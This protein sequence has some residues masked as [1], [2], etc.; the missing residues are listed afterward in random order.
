MN[1]DQLKGKLPIGWKVIK[2]DARGEITVESDE[3]NLIVAG[4][5]ADWILR[6]ITAIMLSHR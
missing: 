6:H 1:I 3:K 2:V 5:D 4:N